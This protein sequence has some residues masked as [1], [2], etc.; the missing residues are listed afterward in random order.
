MYSSLS[1]PLLKRSRR[2]KKSYFAM[3]YSLLLAPLAGFLAAQSA[4]ALEA[5]GTLL[6]AMDTCSLPQPVTGPTSTAPSSETT[7]TPCPGIYIFA[8]PYMSFDFPHHSSSQV[9]TRPPLH[10][11]PH[12]PHRLPAL[13]M[14][15]AKRKRNARG[16]KRKNAIDSRQ[17]T[18]TTME[19]RNAFT[20]TSRTVSFLINLLPLHQENPGKCYERSVP[21]FLGSSN[22]GT[23]T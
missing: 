13:Q 15:S 14:R 5:H 21:S 20:F 3:R 6:Q 11:S 12:L 16:R 22:A 1:N 17:I 8:L 23:L 10:R 19:K 4:Q 9:Q 18:A 7:T 2:S